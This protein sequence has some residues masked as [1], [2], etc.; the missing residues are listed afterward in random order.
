VYV[1][2]FV[3][4]SLLLSITKGYV[5]EDER[6]VIKRSWFGKKIP[7]SEIMGIKYYQR[8][9]NREKGYNPFTDDPRQLLV[10]GYTANFKTIEYGKVHSYCNRWTDVVIIFT[11]HYHPFILS[12]DDPHEFIYSFKGALQKWRRKNSPR[13]PRKRRDRGRRDRK[14]GEHLSEKTRDGRQRDGW[15]WD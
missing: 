12:P 1:P 10:A 13:K 2:V 5:I 7:F 14:E 3:L 11:K 8:A 4:L 15:D 6:L 9:L